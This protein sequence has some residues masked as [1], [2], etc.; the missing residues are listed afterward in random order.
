MTRDYEEY[1][2]DDNLHINWYPGHMKKTKEMVQ[3]NLKLVDVVIELLDARIPLSSKNPEIDKLAHNKPRVVVLNK[4]D[5]SDRAKLNKWISYYQSKGIKA[6]PVDTLKGSG[7]NKIVEECKNVTKEKMDALKEKGRKERAIRVMIVG[8]PNVGKSSLINK[9]TGRKSTQ[10]G[11][12]PGVTKGKQ[13]VRLIGNLELLDTPGILWPKF[14]DQ[15]IALNL[16][17]TRAIKDEILDIDTLGLKFIEKMSDIEPEKLK[18]RYKLDSL[19]E[20]PLETMEMIG[21]KRGF[22]L[23]RNELDYTRIAKTVLNEFREGK[24]GQITLEVPEDIEEA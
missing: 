1:L 5:L 10:T 12:R 2:K 11:D 8:V 18:A 14:E 3:N 17:F 23:G 21:R 15:K 24:L 6:I 20:E 16:A 22:I 7:V 9:L 4:S 13:W 19:G